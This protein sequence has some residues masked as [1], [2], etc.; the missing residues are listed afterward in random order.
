MRKLTGALLLVLAA[1]CNDST[2]TGT[3]T[4]E[5]DYTLQTANA[6]AVP[7]IAVDDNSGRFEVLRGR[8]VLRTNNTFVDSLN[9]RFTPPGGTASTSW[10][11]RQGSYIQTGDNVTLTFQTTTGGL[12]DYYITWINGNALAYAEEGLSLIYRK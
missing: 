3:G 2:G 8:I 5:G 7:T 1:A 4:L 11:V 10:D 12:V 6:Q 9:Y